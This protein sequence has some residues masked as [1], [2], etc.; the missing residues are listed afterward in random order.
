MLFIDDLVA[1]SMF[2][3]NFAMLRS[4]NAF[5]LS[6]AEHETKA[7]NPG[8]PQYQGILIATWIFF[9]L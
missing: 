3:S 7:G 5:F 8:F 1:Y 2:E 6:N 4:H 9:L